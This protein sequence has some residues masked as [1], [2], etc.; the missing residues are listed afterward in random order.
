MNK[1]ACAP[2]PKPCARAEAALRKQAEVDELAARR[3]TYAADMNLVQ[4]ALAVDHL[5]RAQDLLNRNRPKEGETDLRGWEWRY[6]W[7]FCQSDAQSVVT[8]NRNRI[9]SLA[10][11]PDGKWLAVGDV[12]KGGLSLFDLLTREE[13]RVPAGD[14]Y[15]YV[16]FSPREPLLAITTTIGSATPNPQFRVVLWNTATRRSVVELTLNQL[17]ARL[18]FS[19]DGQQLVAFGVGASDEIARWRVAD[20]EKIG[21]FPDAR[22]QHYWCAARAVRRDG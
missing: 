21:R 10:A 12:E 6:L 18:A 20:G 4:R 13:V 22:G 16:A 19:A 3:K 17:C 7:Q 9:G 8:Q 15:V 14:G 5:R 1:P 2:R 11:S